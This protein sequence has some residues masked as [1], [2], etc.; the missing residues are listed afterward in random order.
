VSSVQGSVDSREKAVGNGDV[1]YSVRKRSWTRA[2]VQ[3]L[4]SQIFLNRPLRAACCLLFLRK[5]GEFSPA[6]GVERGELMTINDAEETLGM[7]GDFARWVGL[8]A[9]HEFE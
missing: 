6:D 2:R 7:L 8:E 3:N 4:K 9:E 5:D 1:S